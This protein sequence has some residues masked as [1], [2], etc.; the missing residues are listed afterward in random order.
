MAPLCWQYPTPHGSWGGLRDTMRVPRVARGLKV[1]DS[2]KNSKIVF[3]ICTAVYISGHTNFIPLLTLDKINH[4][5]VYI[6]Q[7]E[8]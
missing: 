5:Q 2:Y 1:E 3:D 8:T 7:Y 6:H 4:N